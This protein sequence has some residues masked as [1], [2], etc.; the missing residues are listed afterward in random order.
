MSSFNPVGNTHPLFGGDSQMAT[1]MR[2]YP[3]ETHALGNP[4][5]WPQSLKNYIRL[6]LH[7]PYPMFLWWS[8]DLYMFHN[9]AYLPALDKKHPKALGEKASIMW[10]EIWWQ[11]GSIVERILAGGEPFYAEELLILLERKGFIEETYWTFSYSPAFDDRGVVNGVFCVCHEVTSALLTRRRLNTLQELSQLAH[12][13]KSVEQ[14]SRQGC[15]VLSQNSAD[16][17]IGLIYLLNE[18][19]KGL[20]LTGYTLIICHLRW[21]NPS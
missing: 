10:S 12:L 14:V 18:G 19:N 6:M 13:S 11:I 5:Q 7:V 20:H 2:M 3:W 9:D 16:I 8:K 21:I 4:E 15:E 1:L 17:P